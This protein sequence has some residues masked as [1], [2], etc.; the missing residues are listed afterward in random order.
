MPGPSRSDAIACL[1]TNGRITGSS[2]EPPRRLMVAT[3]EGIREFRRESFEGPWIPQ[4]RYALAGQHPSALLYEPH[5][6]LL[7][8]GLHYQYGIVA[9]EDGG[10]TWQSRCAGIESGHVYTLAAQQAGE[11]TILYAGTEPAMVYRSEDLGLS[12]QPLASMRAVP[13]TDK[14]WFPHA[15]PHVK[16]IAFHPAEPDTL[17]VCVEQGDLLK[18]VDA[19]RSWRAITSYE[20]PDDKFR[21]DMH[22]VTFR[23]SDPKQIFL[24]SGTGLYYTADAGLSW[25]QLVTPDSRV[26]YPDPFFVHPDDERTVFMAGARQN[27]NP[28]W[29]ATG[30]A[31]PGFLMSGDGGRTWQ[32]AMNGMPHPVRG[33]IE[34][35]AMYR[36]DAGLEF[37]AGTACG[38]LYA[39]RDGAR[40]WRLVSAD[41]PP[42]S[43]GPH[44]RHFLA[45]EMRREVEEKLRALRAFA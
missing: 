43:K 37:F 45:P 33:N 44:F 41:L 7:F 12:W 14:W 13:D 32:E 21:R 38:E 28:E 25:E 23:P 27:P 5:Q 2:A 24:T 9:S 22:R 10:G 31:N 15:A 4:G 19:G 3:V 26:G 11:R 1:S 35:A 42:I 40:S 6:G 18:S 30:T 20:K 36:S 29:G 8:A 17:Y 16:N 39:S 34:A